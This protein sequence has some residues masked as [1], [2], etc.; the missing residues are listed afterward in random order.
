MKKGNI[1]C[2]VVTKHRCACVEKANAF[3]NILAVLVYVTMQNDVN[4]C[5][6]E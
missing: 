2:T 6:G 3:P 1:E 4:L 5:R